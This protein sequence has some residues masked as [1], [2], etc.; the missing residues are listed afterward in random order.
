MVQFSDYTGLLI[1]VLA[2]SLMPFVAM[3][4]T[5]YAKIVVVLRLVAQRAGRSAG[6]A[7]HGAQRHRDPRLGLHHGARRDAAMTS[8]HNRPPPNETV[9][10]H[11]QRARAPPRSRSASF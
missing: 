1:V 11:D 2:I 6:A 10:S 7:E 4:V 3:V 8:L 5:S 9:A